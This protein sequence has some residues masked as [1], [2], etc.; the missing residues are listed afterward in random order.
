[1]RLTEIGPRLTLQLLKIQE[2]M[3]DGSVLYHASRKYGRPGPW[4]A[5][6]AIA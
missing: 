2:G 3:G 6:V 5:H 4:A 1:M